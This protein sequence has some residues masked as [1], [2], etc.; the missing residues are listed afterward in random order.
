VIS[1]QESQAALSARFRLFFGVVSLLHLLAIAT[2]QSPERQ[3]DWL[4]PRNGKAGQQVPPER[5]P[6]NCGWGKPA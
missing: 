2:L 6:A 1:F 3:R 5:I 4:G